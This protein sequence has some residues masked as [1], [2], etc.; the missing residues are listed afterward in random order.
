VR[1]G[2]S[3]W[4]FSA[5]WGFSGATTV[6]WTNGSPSTVNFLGATVPGTPAYTIN[7]TLYVSNSVT[8]M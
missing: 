6:G 3:A 8:I 5:P 1:F 7:G 4:A 2:M